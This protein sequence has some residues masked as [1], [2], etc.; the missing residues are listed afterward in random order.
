MKKRNRL[1]AILLTAIMTFSMLP[2]E[3]FATEAIDT[4]ETAAAA[5]EEAVT[6]VG[7]EQDVET[8][9]EEI[10]TVEEA[11]EEIAD[12]AEAEEVVTE[13]AVTEEAA[14]PAADQE[15]E[16][17]SEEAADPAEAEEIAEPAV[18]T[19]VETVETVE[20]PITLEAKGSDYTVNATFDE[21]AGFPADV[22]LN[23]SEISKGSD[24]YQSYYDQALETVQNE[25]DKEIKL[26]DA[27]FFDITFS[28][29]AGEVEPTG[30][31][32]VSI[33]YRKAIEAESSDDVH[34]LHF[35]DND[36]A[37]PQVMDIETDGRGEKV[38][39]VSFATEGFSVYAVIG[40]GE[41]GNEARATVNFI[42]ANGDT[43]ATMYVKNSDSLDDLETIVYDPGAGALDDGYA[44]YGWTLDKD[45]TAKTTGKTIAQVR[46]DLAA[47]DITEGD[48]VNYYAIILT[49]Y[50]VEFLD[51]TAT[52][53]V[54][55]GSVLVRKVGDEAT[56]NV[57]MGYPT[58]DTH[59]FEGW[60]VEDGLANIT[61]PSGTTADTLFANNT[62]IKIKGNITFKAKAP[63][64]HWLVFDEN[65]RGATYNA[66]RFFENNEETDD[67]G[68]LEM[69]RNGYTFGG[70]YT[71]SACTEGNEFTFGG[72]LED[73]T[74]IYAKWTAIT[75]A[76]Y[77]ILI[78][79]QN[80]N[81]DGYDFE[82]S[83]SLSG[84][85]GSTVNTVTQQ[86][87]GDNAYARI[88]G[89][90][91]QYT[92]FHLDNFDQNVE[93]VPEGNAVVNVYYNRT[94]YTLT[95]RQSRTGTVYKTITALYGQY[96]G[97]NF[98]ISVNGDTTSRWEPQNTSLFDQVLVFIE[99][100]PAGNVTFYRNTSTAGTRYMEFYVEALPGQTADRTWNNK[101]FVKYGSTIPAKYNFFTEA[102]DFLELTGY[103]KYGSDPAFSNGRADVSSG[104]TIYFYYTRQE[105]SLIFM[106]GAYYDGNGNRINDETSLGELETVEGIAYQ[107]DLTSYNENGENY[108]IP[109]GKSGYIFEG[110]YIDDA[111]TQAYTFSTMPGANLTVYAKW[112]QVQYRV[113]LHPNAGDIDNEDK[114]L[115]WGSETQQMNFRV[116]YGGEV[117]TPEGKRTGYEFYGWYLDEGLSAVYPD[118]FKLHEDNT[119]YGQYFSDYDKTKDFTDPMDQWGNGA[120]TNN[121]T[122]R[123]WITKKL[124][125][126]ARW[127][128]VT[129]GADGIN[130]V[131]DANGGTNAPTDG[132]T[133][134]DNSSAAAGAAST[135]AEGKVFK[136][137]VV[138]TWNGSKYEDT[139]TSV[140]VLPGGSYTIHVEDAKI[141]DEN[142]NVVA[143]A[144]VT[145]GHEY[146]YTIQL[147]AEYADVEEVTPTHI[148]WF[149]ND[150]TAAFHIDTVQDGQG[151]A[152]STLGINEAVDVQG[153]LE[154]GVNYTFLGWAR[155]EMTGDPANWETDDTNW[156]QNLTADNLFLYYNKDDGKF[157][158]ESTFTNEVSSVAA[159]E[160]GTYHAMFAVWD[161]IPGYFVK[162]SSGGD[163]VFYKM[164]AAGETVDLTGLVE[165]GYL[166]GGYYHYDEVDGQR[167]K[168]DAYTSNGKELT[169]TDGTY[170]YLKEVDEDHL[171]P[172]LYLISNDLHNGLI[173]GLYGIVS[174]DENTYSEVGFI[175]DGERYE[176]DELGEEGIE[177]TQEGEVVDTITAGD[178]NVDSN[179][180]LGMAEFTDF[181]EGG[182]RIDIKGY[183]KT[184]DSV[185]VTGNKYRRIQ[186]PAGDESYGGMPL[187][188]G[189]GSGAGQTRTG[190]V[191]STSET[192]YEGGSGGRRMG[193][194][195]MLRISAP[196]D[197]IEYRIT[198][199][200]DSGTEEQM[201]EGGNNAGNITYA[202]KSGY[203]FAGWYQD[204]DYTIPADFANV[205]GDMTVYAEY[206]KNKD[207]TLA[208]KR[209][210][211]KNN[212]TTFTVTVT[213]KKEVHLEDVKVTVVGGNTAILGNRTV[214]QSGTGNN[215]KYKTEYKG[216]IS[217]VGLSKVDKF[218]SFVSWDTLDGTVVK[219][220]DKKCTYQL[221][222]VIVR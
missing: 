88:N 17:S 141:V 124:D 125:I 200:Y 152:D 56:Y 116:S 149:K 169:P 197:K 11:T 191:K 83:V 25:T 61:D 2:S 198:K 118:S 32:S 96:I 1:L 66:P 6:S 145:D 163:P 43:I 59:N 178:F 107:A 5:V 166:Y 185:V 65:G 157:Y 213:V 115:D 217:V 143:L 148:P 133:Y 16:V 42:G 57:N 24:A 164:P 81:A 123:F 67:E 84:T 144:D 168:G 193:A 76:P 93:I 159:D 108:K 174:V 120:T 127:S 113:F 138:Q 161:K 3:A 155:V 82:Q 188:T 114:S 53:S 29:E 97:D 52:V 186:F 216:T 41:T 131:Y 40:T 45:Y 102:E 112:R 135:P 71:D 139:S 179:S 132:L 47:L 92:G 10:S 202:P 105:H 209:T 38:D 37:A 189:W 50:T 98:P 54:G 51:S 23:V 26:T 160:N 49:Q 167:T 30:P 137:W 150:G 187:F 101:S 196:S 117:S 122:E 77:T 46:E 119:T 211:T 22:K 136:H 156:T 210:G 176:V 222:N 20:W 35:D 205:T 19:V 146:T 128:K 74:I 18:E 8:T 44:F 78:W 85:V 9:V 110:W 39:E 27:R 194:V 142:G 21:S 33:K 207:V 89:T 204:A 170:Y 95:F 99:V 208:F 75:T 201:V 111:C 58:D 190:L 199:I 203:M 126:Y 134:K 158:S 12:P 129:V 79:K 86:G 63:A 195:R 94:S 62:D 165:T 7:E 162:H 220:A 31:V 69:V 91:Y 13:E 182:A 28:T 34:V 140:T 64:G 153:K 180:L 80:L 103:N 55:S 70:W 15:D 172:K 14:E 130:V 214:K 192:T 151:A 48:V 109:T 219:G 106:D 173:Q 60:L 36:N 183:Y 100:M 104:G 177:V 171:R 218:T 72:L 206:I 212:V 215:V 90:N 68:L 154:R 121:D 147:R 221:G 73:K 184:P 4:G 87:S 175:I 181:V